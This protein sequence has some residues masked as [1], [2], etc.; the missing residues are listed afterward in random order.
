MVPLPSCF[1]SFFSVAYIGLCKAFLGDNDLDGFQPT[2]DVFERLC[3]A[4]ILAVMG[5]SVPLTLE[6]LTLFAAEVFNKCAKSNDPAVPD[7]L[8]RLYQHPFTLAELMLED[9]CTLLLQFSLVKNG[10]KIANVAFLKKDDSRGGFAGYTALGIDEKIDVLKQRLS[11]PDSKADSLALMPRA[12][13]EV[14]I[15]FYW[16]TTAVVEDLI[17]GWAEKDYFSDSFFFNNETNRHELR[18]RIYQART[19]QKH[20]LKPGGVSL[21]ALKEISTSLSGQSTDEAVKKNGFM[22]D[23]HD[24]VTNNITIMAQEK[25]TPKKLKKE[26][27]RNKKKDKKTGDEEDK[28]EE[29]VGVRG[30]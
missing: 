11:D 4:P 12:V 10:T 7:A 14:V 19:L 24:W 23:L 6:H 15:Q 29:E 3:A 26:K 1:F 30:G 5:S 9:L 27:R 8:A 25:T 13:L 21:P 18:F 20:L 28:D 16:A 17:T 2:T 22:R